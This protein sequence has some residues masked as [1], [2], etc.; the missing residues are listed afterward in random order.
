MFAFLHLEIA[1]NWG[2]YF[3]VNSVIIMIMG[4]TPTL[5]CSSD[6]LPM[7]SLLND[8]CLLNVGQS[9]HNVGP[10]LDGCCL[11]VSAL[12]PKSAIRFDKV[13]HGR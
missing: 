12:F 6:L 9:F 1:G 8:R 4:R 7:R 10:A 3:G 11:Y 5:K 2:I 13:S